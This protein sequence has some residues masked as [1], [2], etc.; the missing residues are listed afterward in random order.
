MAEEKDIRETLEIMDKAKREALV[1]RQ[2]EYFMKGNTLPLE[3]RRK[4]LLILKQA[5]RTFE[6]RL[7]EAL[8]LDLGKST[9][10]SYETELGMV[11]SE[12]TFALAN[13]RKWAKRKTVKTPVVH[14]PAKSSVYQEPLGVALILSPWNYPLQLALSPLIACISAGNCAVLRPSHSAPHTAKIIEELISDS[15]EPEYIAVINGETKISQELLTLRFDHIFFTGSPSV[16][17]QVM[18]AAAKHLTPVTLE[19]GGKSPCIVDSTANIEL[20]ARR[21]VW[22]KF[23][24]AGQTCVAPDYVLADERIAERLIERMICYIKA[25]YGENPLES[26]DLPQIINEKHFYR[27]CALI[28]ADKIRHGGG[29]TSENRKIEPTILT[30]ISEDSA[31]MKEEIFGPLLPV[32]TYEKLEE[33]VDFVKQREKPLALYFFSNSLKNEK[34]VLRNISFGG[35]CINDTI[36]HLANPHLGFGGVGQSGMGSYHGESGFKTFSHQKSILK[37]GRI[38]L[39]LRYPPYEGKLGVLRFLLK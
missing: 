13:L 24:N 19:L 3:F 12:L 11:F 37:K 26:K 9:F 1:E 16:G 39:P 27:L 35:G 15:F 31:A 21:I 38:D 10:E 23:L 20:A 8:R 34:K 5:L 33:A 6:P 25:F 30:G 28:E 29:Y 2:H 7:L 14:F 4:Q 22:G 17:R 32:L 18:E 36:M